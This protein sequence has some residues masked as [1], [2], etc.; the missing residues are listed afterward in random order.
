MLRKV[1]LFLVL[2]MAC[3][4]LAGCNG[5][6][7]GKVT[8]SSTEAAIADASV[9]LLKKDIDWEPGYVLDK[10][11]SLDLDT[12]ALD[13][14]VLAFINDQLA[15]ISLDA[16]TTTDAEGKFLFEDKDGSA[17][18]GVLVFK[19]G[20]RLDFAM[21]TIDFMGLGLTSRTI[22]LAPR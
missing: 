10:I 21:T 18:Y 14:D 15:D 12:I 4:L 2:L 7:R 22:S 16:Q 6:I 9:F 13:A 3:S 20:Y 5:P 19:Q 8:D 1:S 17:F 11:A